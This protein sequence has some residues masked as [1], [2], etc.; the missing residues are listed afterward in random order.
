MQLCLYVAGNAPNSN[1]AVANLRIICQEYL[2]DHCQLEIVD[3]FVHPSR[4]LA[5][6]ILVT[7]TLVKQSPLPSAR[8]IG[9]LSETFAVVQA[10]GLGNKSA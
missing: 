2:P 3:V 4:A 6:G 5:D 10:L 8:I 7:P 9:D 1:R